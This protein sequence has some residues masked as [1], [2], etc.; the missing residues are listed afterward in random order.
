[1]TD[2]VNHPS[3]YKVG[4]IETI[5]FIEA[6]GLNYNLGNVI[7]YVTRAGHKN[8]RLE[9]LRKAAW[10]LARE[11][12]GAQPKHPL[13]VEPI[14]VEPKPVEPVVQ[15]RTR[16]AHYRHR[17]PYNALI[18]IN[19]GKHKKIRTNTKLYHTLTMI[20]GLLANGPARRHDIDSVLRET[21]PHIAKHITM[22]LDHKLL[23]VV[24]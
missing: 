6:K 19:H 11:I 9:D 8:D 23:K 5:D 13:I 3:H 18:D 21:D 22:L 10:Y 14:P 7:K 16:R 15:E 12:D 1:M 17:Y 2:N 20:R 4:G 24:S